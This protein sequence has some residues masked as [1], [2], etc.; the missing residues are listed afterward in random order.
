MSPNARKRKRPILKHS[1]AERR[2][3][4]FDGYQ[5]RQTA[6]SE[7]VVE[8]RILLVKN[9]NRNPYCRDQSVN[10]NNANK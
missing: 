3:A 6:N 7:T 2:D 8:E 1:D 10:A 4:K 5:R 9:A